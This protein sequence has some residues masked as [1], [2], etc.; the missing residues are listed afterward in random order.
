MVTKGKVVNEGMALKAC[1]NIH[2]SETSNGIP[3][4]IQ[5]GTALHVVNYLG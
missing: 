2:G 1:G 4:C 5:A 3:C